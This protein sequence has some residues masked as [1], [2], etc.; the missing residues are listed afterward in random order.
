[1]VTER[2]MD[3]VAIRV[4]AHFGFHSVVVKRSRTPYYSSVCTD[5]C[6]TIQIYCA[7]YSPLRWPKSMQWYLTSAGCELLW[8]HHCWITNHWTQEQIAFWPNQPTLSNR[9]EPADTTEFD[10]WH[11]LQHRKIKRSEYCRIA[12]TLTCTS[13]C[14]AFAYISM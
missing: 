10:H 5:T 1:M 4:H 7:V 11:R 13:L 2:E 3:A 8:F 12:A 6:T 9:F 14:G